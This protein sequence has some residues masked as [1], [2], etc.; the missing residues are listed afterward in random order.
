[1]AKKRHWRFFMDS[2]ND[3]TVEIHFHDLQHKPLPATVPEKA[4]PE[5]TFM[6]RNQDG[7]RLAERQLN[8][9]FMLR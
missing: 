7:A 5:G 4:M 1:M 3:L 9:K 8:K 6:Q 2:G